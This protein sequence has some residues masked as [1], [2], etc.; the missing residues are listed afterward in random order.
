MSRRCSSA[1]SV[2]SSQSVVRPS[3]LAYSSSD[4]S[5]RSSAS[6]E[7]EGLPQ[8]F[9]KHSSASYARSL[10]MPQAKARAPVK[11]VPACQAATSPPVTEWAP[12]PSKCSGFARFFAKLGGATGSKAGWAKRRGQAKHLAKSSVSAAFKS[13]KCAGRAAAR[14]VSSSRRGAKLLRKLGF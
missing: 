12:S 10:E 11:E 13:C 14:E 6:G 2:G 1:G 4:Y 3:S 7:S 9:Y 5:R 8:G